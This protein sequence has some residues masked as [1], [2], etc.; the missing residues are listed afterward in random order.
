[1]GQTAGFIPAV[2]MTAVT[3]WTSMAFHRQNKYPSVILL[4][5]FKDIFM[6][7]IFKIFTEFVT[8]LF[9]YLFIYFVF[10]ALRHV[11]S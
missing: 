8:I 9:I 11:R 2:P 4:L 3:S 10:W 7:T 6:W 5:L 1:M